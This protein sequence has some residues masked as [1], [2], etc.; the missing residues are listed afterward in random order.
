MDDKARKTDR[1]LRLKAR[2]GGSKSSTGLV[3]KRLFTGDNSLHVIQNDQ[4][5]WNFKYAEGAVP[6]VLKN[7]SF[8]SF[9]LAYSHAK[10]YFDTRNVEIVGIDD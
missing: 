10:R 5:L 2:E 1:V 3:D 7:Q 9:D 6:P 8:T 4:G